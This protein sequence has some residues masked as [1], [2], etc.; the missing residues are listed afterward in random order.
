MAD[1]DSNSLDKSFFQG[2]FLTVA[3]DK[4]NGSW[5]YKCMEF[6]DIKYSLKYS[7]C[8]FERGKSGLHTEN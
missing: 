1:S 3:P 4:E 5:L 6:K 8:K 7:I 2:T